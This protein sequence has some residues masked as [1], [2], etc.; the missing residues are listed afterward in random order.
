MA[1]GVW[2]AGGEWPPLTDVMIETSLLINQLYHLPQCG[3]GGPLHITTD[4]SNVDDGSLGFCWDQ[5]SL[6]DGWWQERQTEEETDEMVRVCSAILWGLGS[7]SISERG[8]AVMLDSFR[9]AGD[10]Y[11]AYPPFAWDLEEMF[12]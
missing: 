12:A 11:D 6:R 5:V 8:V 10:S 7:M 2:E 1:Q 4:D 9:G 3:T